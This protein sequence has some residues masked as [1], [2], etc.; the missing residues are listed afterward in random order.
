[1]AIV[2]WGR[3]VSQTV[4]V[5]NFPTKY[6]AYDQV[7]GR[8]QKPV[9]G[10]LVLPYQRGLIKS[11]QVVT[12]SSVSSQPQPP[13]PFGSYSY[14]LVRRFIESD[15]IALGVAKEDKEL[16]LA[17][18]MSRNR[19]YAKMVDH[20]KGQK[21]EMMTA[22]LESQKAADM[23]LSGVV[24]LA[25]AWHYLKT[26][27]FR[28]FLRHLGTRRKRK[29][30]GL[31]SNRAADAGSLW[32][33]YWMGWAP[34]ANDLVSSMK[35]LMG[36]NL[37]ASERFRVRSGQNLGNWNIRFSS[38]ANMYSRG[39]RAGAEVRVLYTGDCAIGNPNVVLLNALG[40][41]NPITSIVQIMP[42]SWMVGWFINLEQVLN[43]Y[44][45]LFGFNV[46]N[47]SQTVLVRA[48]HLDEG[49]YK[50]VSGVTTRSWSNQSHCVGMTRSPG[51]TTP[52]LVFAMPSRL[53]VTRAATALSLLA[54]AFNSHGRS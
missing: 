40:L 53:S 45:D 26:G 3:Y 27:R 47:T 6:V 20:M 24:R 28:A 41:V 7:R 5:E 51:L 15:D 32:L 23:I 19:C 39:A 49:W 38:T 1:M 16:A 36:E 9:T 2:Q 10:N 25:T 21:S 50:D 35:I 31:T 52:K 13:Y 8:R 33:E 30:R 44:S 34:T 42:W 4:P 48:Q 29:H 46:S 37:P 14:F 54:G 18:T 12:F 11:N 17:I 22:I 43:S